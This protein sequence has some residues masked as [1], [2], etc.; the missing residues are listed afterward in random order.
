MAMAELTCV[1]CG[2]P[3]A[4][5]GS[6]AVAMLGHGWIHNGRECWDL[7]RMGQQIEQPM[8]PKAEVVS[9]FDRARKAGRLKEGGQ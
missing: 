4:P 1:V 8:L 5:D 3:I 2:K 7:H 6:D 9:I